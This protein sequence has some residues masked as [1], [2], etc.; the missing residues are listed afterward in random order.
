[1]TDQEKIYTTAVPEFDPLTHEPLEPERQKA[2]HRLLFRAAKDEAWRQELITN[3]KPILEQ[4]LGITIPPGVTIQV[5]EAGSTIHLMLPPL[6][7][8]LREMEVSDADLEVRPG[9]KAINIAGCYDRGK[10]CGSILARVMGDG[11]ISGGMMFPHGV[12]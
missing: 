7:P 6:S 11:T 1:M 10:R 9:G 12:F 4:E 2:M 5:H 3:P 8:H